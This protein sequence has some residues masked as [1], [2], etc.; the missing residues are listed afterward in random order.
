MSQKKIS[1]TEINQLIDLDGI[2]FV[3]AAYQAILKRP[4]DSSGERAY[5]K[6]LLRGVSKEEVLVS[7][8]FSKEG[9]LAAVRLRSLT[10]LR[11]RCFWRRYL[12]I[13]F[14]GHFKSDESSSS[15]F[16]L[17]SLPRE[18]VEACFHLFFRR[19]PT[20]EELFDFQFGQNHASSMIQIILARE[21]FL[22]CNSDVWE[23]YAAY[24]EEKNIS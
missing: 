13:F 9:R 5:F 2:A 14:P 11:F 16:C 18:Q 20:E 12:R 22:S 7:L 4:A 8:R 24:L 3:R 1:K 10:A 23:A 19:E 6:S 21:D 17:P 15:S